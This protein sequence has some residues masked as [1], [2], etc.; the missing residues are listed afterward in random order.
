M[1]NQTIF[2][3]SSMP[4]AG[5]TLFQNIVGQNP[6]FYTTP[7]SGLADLV[8][9]SSKYFETEPIF[10][11]T[12]I[13]LN[14]NSFYNFISF[15]MHGYYNK[16]TNK[17]FILDK[18][19]AWIFNKFILNKIN[20]NFKIICLVRDLRYIISSFEKKIQKSLFKGFHVFNDNS[21]TDIYSRVSKYFTNAPL[22]PFLS[23]LKDIIILNQTTNILFLKYEDLCSVPSKELDKFYSF[24]N[25]PKY[26]H[27][28]QNITQITNEIDNF[29]DWADHTIQPNIQP[30]N[31]HFTEYLPQDILN[32][33]YNEYNWYFD[34]F[35]YK[36]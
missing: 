16:V 14:Q 12:D 15:G 2:F 27:N 9:E 5:S 29:N 21:Q 28:F 35:K 7:T 32:Y 6:K 36:K 4:R 1:N 31:Y 22:Y 17:P 33:I 19:K 11:F 3:Q 8:L 13:N 25:L 10:R 20:P 34:F 23:Y 24:L 26:Q 18:G 30:P